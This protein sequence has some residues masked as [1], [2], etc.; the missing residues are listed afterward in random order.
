MAISSMRKF[1]TIMGAIVNRSSPDIK[2]L[3][4]PLTDRSHPLTPSLFSTIFF[5]IGGI[6]FLNKMYHKEWI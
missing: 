2:D 3:L 4:T 1:N 6:I 5:V